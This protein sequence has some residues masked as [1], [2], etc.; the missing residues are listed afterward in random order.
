MNNEFNLISVTA[1]VVIAIAAVATN[2]LIFSVL[3]EIA[4]SY[5][6]P[7]SGVLSASLRAIS[8]AYQLPS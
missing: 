1:R 5:P 3:N 8:S 7:E 4:V 6:T 2:F